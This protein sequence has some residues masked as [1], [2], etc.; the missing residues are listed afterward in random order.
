VEANVILPG[1]TMERGA[2]T[3]S[4]RERLAR[5][6]A[7]S[8]LGVALRRFGA[9]RGVLVLNYHRIGDPR[10]SPF[11]PDVFSATAE[12]FREQIAFVGRHFDVVGP[13]EV[14][15]CLDR[16][17]RSVLITF[18][19][20]YR[21]N[22]EVAYPALRAHGLPATFFVTTGF[23]GRSR[24]SWW[25][26]IAW[27]VGASRRDTLPPGPYL[28]ASL[29]LDAPHRPETRRQVVRVFKALPGN[30][31]EEFLDFI[32]DGTG[33]GRCPPSEADGLWMTWDMVRELRDAG[34]TIGGHTVDHAILAGLSAADQEEQVRGCDA[35]LRA[36]LGTP[37]RF[38]SYPVGL[39]GTFD[40]HTRAC[41]RAVGV[42]LA[43]SGRG[44]FERDSTFDPLDVR[45][46]NVGRSTSTPLLAATTTLPQ[47]FARE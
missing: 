44:G 14:A 47:L 17:G 36:E 37:M 39:P 7:A 18:D 46:I 5:F 19:D 20:G 15:A 24:V 25:D 40:E 21:D 10:E 26:E 23:L 8:G 45:R 12:T 13:E 1:T 4:K 34:M 31:T 30:R 38:F 16:R 2:V 3:P 22:Y 35:Q 11:E 33:T 41:L 32:A 29:S 28:S 9:W 43:F 42:E 6:L 27:M